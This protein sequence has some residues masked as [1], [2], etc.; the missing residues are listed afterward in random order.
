M[1]RLGLSNTARM[2]RKRWTWGGVGEESGKSTI[3]H[4]QVWQATNEKQCGGGGGE[5]L[6]ERRQ[7]VDGQRRREAAGGGACDEDEAVETKVKVEERIE[8]L[9]AGL[10]CGGKENTAAVALFGLRAVLL[11]QNSG[12]SFDLWVKMKLI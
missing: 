3:T 10:D 12:A 6:T 1:R 2:E 8:T 9:Q 7:A 4:L 5:L 11:K